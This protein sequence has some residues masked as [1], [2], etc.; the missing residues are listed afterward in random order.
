MGGDVCLDPAEAYRVVVRMR[1]VELALSAAWADGLLPGEYHSGIGEEAISAGVIAHVSGRDTLAL[2]HRNTAP[3]IAR[4]VDPK[5]LMLEVLGNE[6]GM[7]GGRAGH[8]HLLDPDLHVAAD[9]I[10][11]ASAALAVGNAIALRRL[12]PGRVAIAFHGEAAMNQGM[13]MEAYNLA[14][15]WRLPVVFVCK[16]NKWSITTYSKEVTAGSPVGRARAFGLAVERARGDRVE[17]VYAA[18]GRLI[19][20]ARCGRGPGFL[21]APCHRPAGHFEGDPL[22][23][24]LHHPVTKV[25]AWG[26]GVQ[27][28]VTAGEGGSRSDRARALASLTVRGA[29]AARDWTL[30]SRMDPL[31]RGRK[32]VD[33]AVATRIERDQA[34]EIWAAIDAARAL[35]GQRPVFGPA[36]EEAAVAGGTS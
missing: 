17:S 27:T 18:A 5:A 24:L 7:N 19:C 8:M 33:P 32:L 30:R 21:Y 4:G 22:V 16:D 11:G 25:Q 34:E 3:F 6:H 1:L 26:P 12:H 29:Q 28:A 31:R 13:L 23:A 36:G 2:D 14:V 20:R 35:V 9:G 10:V 15:A